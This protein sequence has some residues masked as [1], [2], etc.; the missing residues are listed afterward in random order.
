MLKFSLFGG[1]EEE[2]PMPARRVRSPPAEEVVGKPA[3][4]EDVQVVA[5][6]HSPPAV[7]GFRPTRKVRELY[8]F[9][10]AYYLL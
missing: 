7:D 8:V 6:A 4:A 3:E 5:P 2:E 9:C 10:L 1:P